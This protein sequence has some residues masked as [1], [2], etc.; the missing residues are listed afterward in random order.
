MKKILEQY[1]SAS[2]NVAD[3]TPNYVNRNANIKLLN[4]LEEIN[5]GK[6]AKNQYNFKSMVDGLKSRQ[7]ENI[8][9]NPNAYAVKSDGNSNPENQK[10]ELMRMAKIT[11]ARAQQTKP[12]IVSEYEKAK[13]NFI[14]VY[15][16]KIIEFRMMSNI[17]GIFEQFKDPNYHEKGYDQNYLGQGVS[18]QYLNSLNAASQAQELKKSLANLQASST[19]EMSKIATQL[20]KNNE[21]QL[22]LQS[23][24]QQLKDITDEIRQKEIEDQ[25]IKDE[26]KRIK[27]V[28][29]GKGEFEVPL[30]PEQIAQ[31]A[32]IEVINAEQATLDALTQEEFDAKFNKFP[33]RK[34]GK[35]SFESNV[36]HVYAT[37]NKDTYPA[38]KAQLIA[39]YADAYPISP[40]V[41]TA[42]EKAYIRGN[43]AIAARNIAVVEARERY[44]S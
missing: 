19:T 5:R 13:N 37:L 42:A 24:T 26:K 38:K 43:N 41:G 14:D 28:E 31:Q 4:K 39:K 35:Q 34:K 17:D 8:L 18:D 33:A 1:S 16:K 3:L 32:I 11:A 27:E 9:Q 21:M 29:E 23:D 22:V 15:S 12:F 36:K 7:T 6:L 10:M 20:Q 44:L 40:V 2:K 25:K 30:T